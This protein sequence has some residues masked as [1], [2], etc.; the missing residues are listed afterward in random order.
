MCAAS[1]DTRTM[2]GTTTKL[3]AAVE[4]YFADLRRVRVSGG[5]TQ[6]R[7][8]VWTTR[9]SP[10]GGRRDAQAERVLR[11]G[12]SRPGRGPSRLR[13]LRRETGAEARAARRSDA[14]ARRGRGEVSGSLR[15][16]HGGRPSG[17]PL[18]GALPA[19][20]RSRCGPTSPRRI[21][22]PT[23][24]ARRA[25]GPSEV[26]VGNPTCCGLRSQFIRGRCTRSAGIR[27]RTRDGARGTRT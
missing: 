1:G 24:P 15:M 6:E 11:L 2:G 27:C 7:F 13:A 14:R 8:T 23:P 17:R 26:P 18:L 21:R 25:D 12:A 19:H 16:G 5:A 4:E 20:P 3:T 10:D 22:R 9:Q